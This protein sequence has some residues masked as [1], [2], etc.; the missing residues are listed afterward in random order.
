MKIR[1]SLKKVNKTIKKRLKK[2]EMKKINLMNWED[3]KNF[4][5]LI[6]S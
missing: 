1:T 5:I 4:Q 6:K 2:M 3:N